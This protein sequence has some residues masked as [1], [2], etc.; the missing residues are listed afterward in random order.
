MDL[1]FRE[2]LAPGGFLVYHTFM[3][4]SPK[5]T[6]SRYKLKHGELASYFR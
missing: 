2:M 6:R 5:P 4:S 1:L 3:E